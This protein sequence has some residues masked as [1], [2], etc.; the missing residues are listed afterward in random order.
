TN[1][2]YYFDDRNPSDYRL[3]GIR[4]LIL[5]AGGRPPV[6]SRLAMRSGPYWLW[7]IDGAGYVQA[8]QII[9]EIPANR[10]NVGTRSRPLP[11]SGRAADGAYVSVRYGS[12]DGGDGR[13][14][15]VRS[16]SSVGPVS[17]ERASLDDGEAAATARMRRPGVV[18][19]STSYDPG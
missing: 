1:P 11:G 9:G 10:T 8:G 15:A 19:L 13:L 2:E 14:P 16:Q 4:Y 6:P 5:P 18:V 3:F 17:A 7:A 12:G